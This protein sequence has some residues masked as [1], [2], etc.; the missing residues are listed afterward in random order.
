MADLVFHIG[1]HK[2]GTTWLQ[3]GYFAEHPEICFVSDFKAPWNDSFLSYLIGTTVRKFDPSRCREILNARIERYNSTSYKAWVVSA[4]RLSGHPFSGGYD[5]FRIAE[6]I[7]KCFP[8]ARIVCVIRNQV[9]MI[10]SVYQQ[11]VKEGYLGT[12]TALFK[13]NQWKGVAFS[14]CMYEYDLLIKKYHSLFPKENV[15][16]LLHEQLQEDVKSFLSNLALFIGVDETSFIPSNLNK[17]V[18]VGRTAKGI[19]TQRFLNHFRKSELNPFP[20]IERRRRNDR[21]LRIIARLLINLQSTDAT[22][23]GKMKEDVRQ[24][25]HE[26]NRRLRSL[27][28]GNLSKYF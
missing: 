13:S 5:S 26:P 14:K 27:V 19:A 7:N 11:L 2:T 1:Y 28:A 25:Y 16:V 10:S 24:Y 6:R 22:L 12:C 15:L 17:A 18:N 9:D 4:E 23:C 21:L 20:L 8:H 3:T